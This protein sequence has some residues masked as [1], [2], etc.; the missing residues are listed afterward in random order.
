VSSRSSV[1]ITDTREFPGLSL[2]DPYRDFK[3]SLLNPFSCLPRHHFHLVSKASLKL[4]MSLIPT[5]LPPL[6]YLPSPN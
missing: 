5:L 2:Y 4:P 1:H 6:A 3:T